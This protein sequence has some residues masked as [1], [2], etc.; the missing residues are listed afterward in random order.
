MNWTAESIA[1]VIVMPL[2][3]IGLVVGAWWFRRVSR[4]EAETDYGEPGLFRVLAVAC[5][6]GAVLAV[7]G[8]WWGMYPWTA[9]YHAY[10]PVSGTV[11]TIDSRIVSAGDDGG[12]EQKY[13]V[14]FAG[15]P[16]PY[17]VIDTRAAAVRP[18]DHLEIA[19]VRRWQQAG[20]DGYD[21]MFGTSTRGGAA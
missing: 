18:G 9:A 14:T 17:G 6:V 16:Q 2:L 3:T 21:C 4:R 15:N 11:A 8:T 13:V 1:T 10:Q 7:A 12:S 19:C 20:T 5:V